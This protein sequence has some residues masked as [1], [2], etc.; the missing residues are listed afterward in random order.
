MGAILYNIG[1]LHTQLGANDPRDT[2]DGMKMACTHFQCAAWTFQVRF[3]ENFYLNTWFSKNQLYIFIQQQ[4]KDPYPQPPGLELSPDLMEFSYRICLAQAQECI[5]EK[6]MIDNRKP[7]IIGNAC[8]C[9]SVIAV[10]V[11]IIFL[12]HFPAKVASAVVKYYHVA[13]SILHHACSDDGNMSE[14]VGSKL[15]KVFP[16]PE[17]VDYDFD[18]QP[19]FVSVS[20]VE[21]IREI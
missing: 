4:L 21:A 17:G 15:F 3:I 18:L 11:I 8:Y 12:F 5:L 6:S 1:A 19:N 16:Q 20:G 14:T 7:I 2:P 9:C 13:S 10:V